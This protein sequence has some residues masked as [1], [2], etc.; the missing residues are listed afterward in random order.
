[1]NL[2]SL[3]K[4]LNEDDNYVNLLSRSEKKTKKSY[5]ENIVKI[6]YKLYFKENEKYK[7]LLNLLCDVDFENDY[8]YWTWIEYALLLK[9][10]D[11]EIKGNDNSI[12]IEKINYAINSG[13]ELEVYVKKNVIERIKLNSFEYNSNKIKDI[14]TSIENLMR[15]LKI[16]FFSLN[17]SSKV[18]LIISSIKLNML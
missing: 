6:T 17:E 16:R 1:M 12:Y 15:L 9:I 8:N 4:K 13:S 3:I 10:Y 5:L 14:D 7:N 18:D 11:N 2:N